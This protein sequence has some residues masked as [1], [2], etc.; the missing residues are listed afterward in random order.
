MQTDQGAVDSAK[1]NLAYCHIVSPIDGQ[2]GLRQVDAGNYVQTS[3]ATGLVVITQMQPI[4]VVFSVPEDNLPEII[5][6]MRAG[7][8]M[9]VDAYD[10]ANVRKLATGQL[11]TLDNQIDTTTGTVKLRAMFANPDEM[12]YPNQFVNARLLVNTMREY[13]PRAGSGGAARRAGH[14]RLC[15]QCE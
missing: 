3:S 15:D 8:T 7:A 6:R 10:R 11:A 2:V 13:R 1:L 12:L 9:S 5:L 14:V 4:S